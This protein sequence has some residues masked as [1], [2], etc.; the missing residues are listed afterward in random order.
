MVFHEISNIFPMMS[1][2]EQ[3]I[4]RDDIKQNGL[5]E[6]IWT[7]EGKI[8][9]GRNRFLA[10]Q[11]TGTVPRFR[12]W[13]G[14]GSLVEF[15]ISLNLHRRHLD[16]SQR[17]MV[18]VK[19]VP[20]FEIEAKQRQLATQLAG[21]NPDG[22]PKFSVSANLRSPKK[23]KASDDAARAVNVSPRT[24][25]NA[26][27][28][29]KEGTPELIESVWSGKTAV[30]RAAKRIV[31]DKRATEAAQFADAETPPNIDIRL[32]DFREV[33]DDIPDKSVDLI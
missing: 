31:T 12:A 6:P 14:S 20:W 27:K 28:V 8:I 5:I 16:D 9:D 22:T 10:C 24:M 33:L 11:N 18:G 17:S 26:I 21:R 32:G 30:S 19:A 25:Q 1:E 3:K 29:N 23:G 7:Y 15:V 13:D 2:P 4:L